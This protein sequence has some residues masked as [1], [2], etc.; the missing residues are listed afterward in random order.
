M[1]LTVITLRGFAGEAYV[2]THVGTGNAHDVG[3][4]VPPLWPSLNVIVPASTFGELEVSVTW[5]E[6]V[7]VLFEGRTAEVGEIVVLVWSSWFTVSIDV[8]ALA[9]WTESPP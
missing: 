8:P 2:V 6:N 4:K 1:A 7:R 9:L 5:T 3:L